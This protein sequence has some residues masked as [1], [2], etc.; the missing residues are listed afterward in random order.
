MRRKAAAQVIPRPKG[1]WQLGKKPD[2][3]HKRYV[4][5]HYKMCTKKLKKANRIMKLPH[6]LEICD[7]REQISYEDT[8]NMETFSDG[9]SHKPVTKKYSDCNYLRMQPAIK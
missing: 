6:R 5:Q 9:F 2:H 3:G 8:A 1:T 4:Q 7:G